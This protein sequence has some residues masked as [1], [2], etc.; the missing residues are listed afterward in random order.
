VGPASGE[1]GLAVGMGPVLGE[2]HA[3]GIPHGTGPGIG[4]RP[5]IEWSALV[6]MAPLEL[7]ESLE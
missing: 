5:E 3:D 6:G 1:G 4:M 7:L 2:E